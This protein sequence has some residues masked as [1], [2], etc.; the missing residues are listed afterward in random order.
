MDR[1]SFIHVG[2]LAAGAA[3][4][5]R[6]VAHA[7]ERPAA[8]PRRS[9][10]PGAQPAVVTPNG[11]TLPLRVVDGVKVGHLVVGPLEHEFAPGLKCEVWGYNGSTPG[12]TIEAVEGDRLRIYVTNSLP[13]PSTVHW[14]G[15]V[16]PN[17]MDGVAG[18]NQRPIP[19]GETYVYEFVV[20][21]PG[22]YMYHSHYDEMTQIA[23]GAVGMFVVHPRRPRGPRVDRDFVLMAHEWK[24]NAGA[25]RPDPNAMSD[26][27][28]LTF[29]GKAFPAT[30]PLLVGRGERVRIRL[31]NLGPMDHHPIH[32][33]GLWFHVTATDG[34]YVPESAQYPETTVLVPVG[35]TRVIEF[36]PEEPGD[37]AMHCH[38]THHTMMQMGHGVPNMVGADTRALDR[39]M[40]RVMPGYMTMGTTGMGGMGEMHM[41]IP[42]N[43][44]PMRG[45]AGPF[46]YIDMGG[47][48]TIVKV[49]DE[50][51][52]ADPNGWY[53]HPAG[54]VA[55]PASADRMRAD[56]INP[57][58]G[59]KTPD[60]GG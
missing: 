6:G 3:L 15:L 4:I 57:A 12:P 30:A 2:G 60:T 37:W 23:L 47:M 19:P 26:F 54:T 38:M 48:F 34:G 49:R 21:H 40:S 41:P 7:Q 28:V 39:R 56:G 52:K 13:E 32:I 35:S 44:L 36:V 31:G 55:G 25:R 24:I 8:P 33:H 16:L 59:G 22:T 20:R 45:G 5:T 17:G 11:S 27:N 9:A 29:N 58:S 10:A 53:E 51:D 43:S 1:R 50:P 46:S 18:L 42:P 14:H